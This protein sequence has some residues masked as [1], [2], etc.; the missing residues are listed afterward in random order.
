MP[1]SCTYHAS[2]PCPQGSMKKE[3]E[4]RKVKEKWVWV[5]GQGSCLRGSEMWLCPHQTALAQGADCS[6]KPSQDKRVYGEQWTE[7]SE[8][9]KSPQEREKRFFVTKHRIRI[10]VQDRARAFSVFPAQQRSLRAT[11]AA[12]ALASSDR[13]ADLDKDCTTC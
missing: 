11:T 7:K 13:R 5:L 6:P 1:L 4:K 8:V 10:F 9:G 3:D 12:A 2:H